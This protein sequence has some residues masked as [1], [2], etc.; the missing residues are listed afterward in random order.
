MQEVLASKI[1]ETL[2]SFYHSSFFGFIKFLLAIYVTVL[3]ADIILIVIL[4]GFGYDVRVAL[5]GMD[6]P[7]IS[8]EKMHKKWMQI[9][10]RIETGNISQYKAAILEADMMANKIFSE[11]RIPGKNLAERL[12]NVK[13]G[14]FA[15]QAELKKAHQ[16]S[17][18]I[19]HEKEFL[20]EK[21]K[22]EEVL[23]VYERLLRD[24]DLI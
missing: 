19:I 18:K 1:F 6:M 14:Q 2:A 23:R 15:N 10:A 4:R 5:R 22:A 3:L 9:L 24:L 21:E 7:A 16:V 13:P 12:E 11:L 20:I 17:N 8:K